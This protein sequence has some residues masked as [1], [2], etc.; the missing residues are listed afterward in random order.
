MAAV[1]E[2]PH[3]EVAFEED[4]ITL[5]IENDGILNIAS[6]GILLENGWRITP[7]TVLEV[8]LYCATVHT[9]D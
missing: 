8:S 2:G 3:Q 7:L 9:A 5:D 6:N 4:K 1:R